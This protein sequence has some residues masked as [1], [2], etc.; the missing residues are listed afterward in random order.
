ML[1]FTFWN[2]PP[3]PKKKTS[4]PKT[5]HSSSS[6][7]HNHGNKKWG[8]T[9]DMWLISKTCHFL[10]L[11]LRKKKYQWVEYNVTGGWAVT[12]AHRKFR[13]FWRRVNTRIATNSS[14]SKG[15]WE[16]EFP[17]PLVGYLSFQEGTTPPEIY[18]AKNDALENISPRLFS[19]LKKAVGKP[20]AFHGQ[21]N[22]CKT[23][24]RG[25]SFFSLK[26]MAM[27]NYLLLPF[28]FFVT[29]LGWLQ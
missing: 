21:D 16:D 3:A 13:T 27:M 19:H 24:Y 22:I 26:R 2:G 17:F 9:E 25:W 20:M 29:C 6:S 8:Q 15:S 5:C 23:S 4:Q 14:H 12:T 11:W 10:L 1:S 28:H 7:S 18:H